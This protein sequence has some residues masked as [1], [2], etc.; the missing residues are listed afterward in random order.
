MGTV[1]LTH[2]DA[3]IGKADERLTVKAE[4]KQL[5]DVPFIK[6]DGIVILGGGQAYHLRLS[7]NF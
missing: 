2:E 5:L 6:I 1:Y 4:K 7:M 3:F